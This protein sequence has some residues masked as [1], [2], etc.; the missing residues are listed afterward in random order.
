M[1]DIIRRRGPSDRPPQHAAQRGFG[2]LEAIVALTLLAGAG[3]ALFAWIQQNLQSASRLRQHEQEARLLLSAQSLAQL[4]NPM[5]TPT[6]TLEAGELRIQWRAVLQEPE[7]RNLSFGGSV[8]G[9]FRLGLYHLEI[10]ALDRRQAIQVQF[11]QLQVGMRRD[12]IRDLA[13]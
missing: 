13:P 8:E 12:E 2:L 11:R 4:V 6:G 10:T 7:R 1:N 9:P 3:M 5:A